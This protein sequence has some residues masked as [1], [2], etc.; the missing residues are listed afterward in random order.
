MR[1]RRALLSLLA[2]MVLLVATSSEAE[3]YERQWQLGAGLGYSLLMTESGTPATPS[4]LHGAGLNLSVTYGL[5]DSINLLGQVD[6]SAHPGGAPVIM[7]GASIGAAYVLDVL[8][9][10]PWVGL[11]AGGYSVTALDPCVTTNDVSCTS[12]RLGLSPVA[13]LDYQVNRSFSIG[14]TGRYGLLIGSQGTVDH[15][16]SAFVRAQYIW[17]Y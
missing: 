1:C 5:N 12:F 8:R 10:V 2:P 7:S 14:A 4:S 9:W 17:G 3:A 15:S 16:I 13:G 6:V 11:T